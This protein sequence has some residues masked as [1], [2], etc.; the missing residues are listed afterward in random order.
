MTLKPRNRYL[1]AA[2]AVATLMVV[3]AFY[4]WPLV[5]GGMSEP[6]V[7][8]V[9]VRSVQA[10]PQVVYTPPQ[11]LPKPEPEL[12]LAAAAAPP[13]SGLAAAPVR[14]VQ[15]SSQRASGSMQTLGK[16]STL[17]GSK[18]HKGKRVRKTSDMIAA[19]RLQRERMRK[20]AIERA[21]ARSK[22]RANQRPPAK[23]PTKKQLRKR[24]R[25]KKMVAKLEQQEQCHELLDQIVQVGED[26]WWIGQD[27]VQCYRAHPRQFMRMGGMAWKEDDRGKRIGLRVT[28]S[29]SERGDVARAVGFK[30]GDVLR[31]LNGMALRNVAGSSFAMSQLLGKKLKIKFLRGDEEHVARLRVVK[32]DLLEEARAVAALDAEEDASSGVEQKLNAATKP[33]GPG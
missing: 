2:Q 16:S 18:A 13:A 3:V 28:V 14:A 15:V 32:Q 30:K 33:K 1:L 12:V 31:S 6:S 8:S 27:I 10:R 21:R 20:A 29:R 4:V 25:R 19:R 7:V 24:E 11:P 5:L 9:E 26:E 22:A 23:P 17:R